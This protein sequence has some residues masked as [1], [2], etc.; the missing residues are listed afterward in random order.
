MLTDSLRRRNPLWTEATSASG[1]EGQETLRPWRSPLMESRVSSTLFPSSWFISEHC[2]VEWDVP[3]PPGS[4]RSQQRSRELEGALRSNTCTS[5]ALHAIDGLRLWSPTWH[6]VVRYFRRILDMD[7][8][9]KSSKR[10]EIHCHNS[11]LSFE[12]PSGVRRR[13]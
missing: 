12:Q 5:A 2:R 13:S 10:S 8:R 6:A 1:S 3:D 7:Q 9:A 4:C 11:Q